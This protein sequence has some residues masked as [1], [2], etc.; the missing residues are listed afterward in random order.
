MSFTPLE[1]HGEGRI[2]DSSASSSRAA[3][4]SGSSSRRTSATTSQLTP[5]RRQRLH[6]PRRHVPAA[7]ARGRRVR[8]RD[9]DD[10]GRQPAAAA[11]D[12]LTARGR[13]GASRQLSS[14]A[15]T[16]SSTL[17]LSAREIGQPSFASSAAVLER[18]PAVAP[19]TSPRT[20]IAGDTTVQPA[21]S[22][23]AVTS[24]WTE[25]GRRRRAGLGEDVRAGHREARRRGPRRG[26]PRASSRRRARRSAMPRSSAGR[27]K[28]PVV[29]AVTR[30]AAAR[31]GRRSR[32]LSLVVVVAIGHPPGSGSL[33]ESGPSSHRR[34]VPSGV[35][36][37]RVRCGSVASRRADGRAGR[38]DTNRRTK[39]AGRVT[40]TAG[41]PGRDRRRHVPPCRPRPDARPRS[42]LGARL[43]TVASSASSPPSLAAP[44]GAAAATDPWT[45]DHGRAGDGRRCS[46]RTGRPPGSCPSGPTRG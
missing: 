39:L 45:I 37:G 14:V 32:S 40:H 33:G 30:A 43:A 6:V 8:R 5:L 29:A 4:S 18:S 28:T 34:T 13:R 25:S 9:P 3:T 7:A 22:L 17:P 24:T 31:G 38:A 41:G 11:D 16:D 2:V 35:V 44:A 1:R 46:T 36:A 19:G 26:A 42:R 21:S 20:V 15:S 12:R 23:S 10:H 27:R